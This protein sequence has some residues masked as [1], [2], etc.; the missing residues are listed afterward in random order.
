M[1]KHVFG[2]LIVVLLALPFL[3]TIF[4][5]TGAVHLSTA[6]N[7]RSVTYNT[8][9]KWTSDLYGDRLNYGLGSDSHI[10]FTNFSMVSASNP[11]WTFGVV[12]QNGNVTITAIQTNYIRFLG[13]AKTSDTLNVTFYYI[14]LPS[15]VDIA[16]PSNVSIS[17]SGYYITYAA[18]VAAPAPAV[19]NDADQTTLW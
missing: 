15:Q 16:Q 4:A 17:I 3:P 2:F 19:Y 6:Y 8:Y 11:S 10:N 9:V 1:V 18:W 14:S 13:V 7:Y 5:D 12:S